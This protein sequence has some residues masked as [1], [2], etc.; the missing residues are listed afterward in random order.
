MSCEQVEAGLSAYLDNMLAPEESR[1]I[2][3]HLQSCPRCMALLAEL[4]QNDLLLAHLPR[5]GPS[6]ALHERIFSVP[7]VAEL[8]AALDRRLAIS[9][10]LTRPLRPAQAPSIREIAGRPQPALLPRGAACEAPARP[11]R[12]AS[13][14]PLLASPTPAAP[15]AHRKKSWSTPVK[16]AVAAALVVALGT[17]GLLSVS[18]HRQTVSSANPAGAITPP[19]AG[20]ATGQSIPLAA[21]TRFVFLRDGAL[22]STLVD[23]SSRQA[24]RLTPAGVMVAAGWVVSPA[25]PGH[26]AGDMLAYIDAQ[27]GLVHT[28]RSDGQQDTPIA[29]ALFKNTSAAAWGSETG[30]AILNG[31]VWSPDGS[32][33]AFVG[34]PGDSRQTNLYLYATATGRVQKVAPGMAGS[35]SHP[36]W[37][38]DGTRLAFEVAHDGVVSILDYNVQS[39]ETLDLSNLAAA[40]G[41]GTN[42][43]LTLGWS[44]NASSP[45]VTWSLGSIGHI[46]SVWVHRVGTG[47]ASY[48]QLLA[49][50]DYLQALYNPNGAHGAGS[51]LL[52][53]ALAGQPGDIWR[54]DLTPGAGLVPLSSGKQVSFV[55]WSPDGSAIFYLD[56]QSGGVGKGH[57]VNVESGTD[58]FFSSSVAVEPAPAWSADSRQL[59]YSAGTGAGA[60]L[61]IV[62]ASSGHALQLR[63]HGPVA[64]LTWSPAAP[65]QLIVAL[66]GAAPGIYLVDT[67]HNTSLQLDRQGTSGVLQWTEIP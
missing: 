15:R 28:I 62:N 41:N 30:Q 52:V 67:Q 23:G 37:S 14:S 10:E 21:G 13:L 61:N 16:M 36:A 29:Q 55:R 57:L 4:R 33:L 45:A 53:A 34:D 9:D 43:V 12:V 22:W 11:A 47:S 46:S 49:S 5:I 39:H 66:N 18:L 8:A 7:E 65:H 63:L 50:G 59:A 31:L 17:A 25:M 48:P 2:T 27:K 54:L 35:V 51:W 26:T 58:Q 24:E 6:P 42:G 44:L 64:T 20:P 19:A 38:P 56:G 3:I 1:A 60:A 40:Q 32:T